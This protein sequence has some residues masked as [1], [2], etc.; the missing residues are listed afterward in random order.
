M[1]VDLADVEIIKLTIADTMVDIS[2]RQTGGLSTILFMYQIA[3]KVSFLKDSILLLKAWMTYEASLL[4]S[5][6]ANMATYALYVLVVFLI[7]NFEVETPMEVLRLFFDYFGS[8][9]WESQMI[10]IFGA[11][12]TLNFYD[13]LKSEFNFDLNAMALADRKDMKQ[14]QRTSLLF[15]PE[16]LNTLLTSFQVIKCLTASPNLTGD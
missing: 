13:R 16:E 1:L 12:K 14:K 4:G 2:I 6:A 15:A 7:N 11:V 8:F 3:K 10:T 9:D 5:H